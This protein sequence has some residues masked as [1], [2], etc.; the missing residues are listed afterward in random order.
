MNAFTMDRAGTPKEWLMARTATL[1]GVPSAQAA[2]I[3]RCGVRVS[4]GFHASVSL[5]P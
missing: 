1:A 5:P 2:V 3:S 4:N